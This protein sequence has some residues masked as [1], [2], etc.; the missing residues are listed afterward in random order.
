MHVAV[1]GTAMAGGAAGAKVP[2]GAVPPA[3]TPAGR[4]AAAGGQMPP[5][6]MLQLLASL[7]I[8]DSPEHPVA[9]VDT[10]EGGW[11]CSRGC[12]VAQFR[13]CPSL[14]QRNC[15]T[16]VPFTFEYKVLPGT[17]A[18]ASSY[19]YAVDGGGARRRN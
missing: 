12:R 15:C 18:D 8:S 6:D 5:L 2:P 11:F 10:T 9:E 7:Q 4:V 19:D 17:D 3:S 1:Q 13:A 14:R 16:G